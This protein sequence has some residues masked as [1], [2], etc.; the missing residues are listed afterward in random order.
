M[1]ICKTCNVPM[2]GVMSF[3]R[4][5]REKFYRCPKCKGETNHN[6]LRNN[7]LDFGEI[8]YRESVSHK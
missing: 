3:S 4:D 5:R 7:D 8:L 2:V 1:Q 6:L